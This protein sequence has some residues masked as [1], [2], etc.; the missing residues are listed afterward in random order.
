MMEELIAQMHTDLNACALKYDE[1]GF[2]KT[3]LRYRDFGVTQQVMFDEVHRYFITYQ[4]ISEAESF[5]DHLVNLLDGICCWGVLKT[6][7]IYANEFILPDWAKDYKEF[8]P[9]LK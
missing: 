2:Y 4:E 9:Q 6:C 7:C 3:V 5:T 1:S 8:R